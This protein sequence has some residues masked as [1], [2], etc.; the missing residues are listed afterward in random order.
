MIM[1][2]QEACTRNPGQFGGNSQVMADNAT[3]GGKS[4]CMA[5]IPVPPNFR[6][7]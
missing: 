4:N 1:K 2:L 5:H 7:Q 3:A 6:C